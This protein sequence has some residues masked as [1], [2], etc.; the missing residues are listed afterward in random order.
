MRF[1]A[2]QRIPVIP[3]SALIEHLEQKTPLPAGQAG[4]PPR[5]V[6][7]THGR[8]LPGGPHQG[9]AGA[10]AL[11]LSVHGV[12]LSAG[13][14]PTRVRP[15]VGGS[16]GDVPGGGR[17]RKPFADAPF[18]DHPPR[19]M[20]PEE[21]RAWIDRELRES[22]REIE[23]ELRKPV[24][25]LAY[26]YGG[27]DEFVAERTRAAGYRAALTCDDGYVTDGTDPWH[28]SRHLVY[29]RT[30]A[31]R[32]VGYLTGSRYFCGSVSPGW[33]AAPWPRS[34]DP[35]ADRQCPDILPETAKIVVDQLGIVF[36]PPP[37][38]P[39]LASCVSICLRKPKRGYYL[40]ASRSATGA[41]PAYG[42]RPPGYL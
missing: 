29:R 6:V 20:G 13:C 26:P 7:I 23:T 25:A 27:Y 8:R 24:T 38:M 18:D 3:L 30:D 35:G 19:A 40:S 42:E 32:F 12:R 36:I 39:R 11:W 22:K 16:L 9:V 41:T 14:G 33:G 37:S 21:Y 10:P 2:V 4:L 34:R 17:Y 15:D 5:A 28:L 1:L 31:K